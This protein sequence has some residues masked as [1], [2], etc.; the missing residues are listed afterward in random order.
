MEERIVYVISFQNNVVAIFADENS[1]KNEMD[2]YNWDKIEQKYLFGLF[3][4]EE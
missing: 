1:L 2:F 4:D 3:P